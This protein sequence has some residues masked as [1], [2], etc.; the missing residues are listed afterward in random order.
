MNKFS[1]KCNDIKLK[2]NECLGEE[3]NTVNLANALT[4]CL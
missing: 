1:G 2:L 4:F 3:V